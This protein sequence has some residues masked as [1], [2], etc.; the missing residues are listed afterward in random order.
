VFLPFMHVV[1]SESLMDIRM[2]FV[3]QSNSSTGSHADLGQTS[4]LVKK[5]PSV[6]SEYT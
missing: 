1:T 2:R 6:L 5:G 4:R 3:I